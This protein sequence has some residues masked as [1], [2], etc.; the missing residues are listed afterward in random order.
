MTRVIY[1]VHEHSAALGR[2]GHLTIDVR[3]GGRDHQPRSV[4]V[5]R[6]EMTPDD[7][8]TRAINCVMGDRRNHRDLRA[9]RNELRQLRQRNRTA[10][11]QH[12][13][14]AGEVQENRQQ[15]GHQRGRNLITKKA[16]KGV[17]SGPGRREP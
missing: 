14:S 11:D 10:A 3:R 12:D 9:R 1:G 16:R 5:V 13:P 7:V 17:P 6:L 2:L 8:D 4:Q 15:L